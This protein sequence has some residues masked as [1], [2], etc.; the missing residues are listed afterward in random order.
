MGGL[1]QVTISSIY[2]IINR[3]LV[4]GIDYQH[5]N[6]NIHPTKIITD[7]TQRVGGL[8]RWKSLQASHYFLLASCLLALCF[9]LLPFRLLFAIWVIDQ[10]TDQ[11]QPKHKVLCVNRHHHYACVL[12]HP[13]TKSHDTTQIYAHSHPPPPPPPY[14]HTHTHTHT[15]TYTHTGW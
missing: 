14:T 4:V 10:F 8:Y 5:T 1:H 2:K 6:N 11:F 13:Q 12:V 15:H 7:N 9:L 3:I